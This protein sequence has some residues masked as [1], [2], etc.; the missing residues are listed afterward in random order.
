[1]NG[2]HLDYY[3]NDLTLQILIKVLPI[4]YVTYFKLGKKKGSTQKKFDEA[5]E[6]NEKR[7]V[8]ELFLQEEVD[9]ME[10][11]CFCLYL[12]FI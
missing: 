5:W 4:S 6:K 3:V 2:I 10:K 11:V 9:R 1:M 12:L 8:E 7:Q